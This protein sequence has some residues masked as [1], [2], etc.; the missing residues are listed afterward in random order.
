MRLCIVCLIS[1]SIYLGFQKPTYA[2]DSLTLTMSGVIE[3]K[4]TIDATNFTQ[5]N[6]SQQLSHSTNLL[7]DCNRPMVLALRSDFGG[8]KLLNSSQDSINDYEVKVSIDS[9]DFIIEKNAHELLEEQ[10]FDT[11]LSI[12]FKTVG[13]LEVNLPEPLIYAGEYKDTLHID[14]YPNFVNNGI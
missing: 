12:P 10:R 11:N 3:D 2:N 14:V 6:F 5:F 7:I 1:I 4:C 9:L 8:M 13:V